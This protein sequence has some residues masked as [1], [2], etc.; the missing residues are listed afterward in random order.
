MNDHV[1]R[2]FRREIERNQDYQNVPSHDCLVFIIDIDL[3]MSLIPIGNAGESFDKISE[4]SRSYRLL[5]RESE[6]FG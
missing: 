1:T 6:R 2:N 4:I 3:D 5:A